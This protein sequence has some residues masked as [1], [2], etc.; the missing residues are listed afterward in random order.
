MKLALR[1]NPYLIER[2]HEF[3]QT[4]AHSKPSKKAKTEDKQ[5]KPTNASEPPP[6]T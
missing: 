4:L 1:R 6:Q 2:F 3:T 5:E